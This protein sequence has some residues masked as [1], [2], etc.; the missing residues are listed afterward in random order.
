M[1]STDFIVGINKRTKINSIFDLSE[2]DYLYESFLLIINFTEI[3]ETNSEFIG[4]INIFEESKS[5]EDLIQKNEDFFF[6]FVK[7]RKSF[8]FYKQKEFYKKFSHL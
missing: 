3:N 7:K 8:K 5:A 1:I 6:K 2:A 4:G